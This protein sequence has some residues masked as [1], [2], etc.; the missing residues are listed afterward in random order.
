MYRDEPADSSPIS[1]SGPVALTLIIAMVGT[2]VLGI[3]PGPLS[4]VVNTAAHSF[5]LP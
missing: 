1:L 5:F 2:L 4:E 3:Y